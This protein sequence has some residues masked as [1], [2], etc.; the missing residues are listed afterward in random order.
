MPTRCIVAGCSNTTKEGVSLHNFPNDEKSGKRRADPALQGK[1]LVNDR[2]A[3]YLRQRFPGA[4]IESAA[5]CARLTSLC[6]AF[7]FHF[8]TS[9]LA[10]NRSLA[11]YLHFLLYLST[12]SALLFP[13]FRRFWLSPSP[14]EGALDFRDCIWLESFWL[15][16][17]KLRPK[18]FIFEVSWALV[19]AASYPAECTAWPPGQARPGCF[20]PCTT[21]L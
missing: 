2:N 20:C 18:P 3:R 4:V 5:G 8:Y 11:A 14:L 13:L 16:H 17:S 7:P 19:F 1:P 6:L 15:F 12:G 9:A 21:V 10:Y